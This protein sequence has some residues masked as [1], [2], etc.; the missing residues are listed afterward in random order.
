[1]AEYKELYVREARQRKA[2]HNELVELKYV[3]VGCQRAVLCGVVLR[4]VA[5]RCVVLCCVVLC[6]VVLCCVVLCCCAVLR[7]AALCLAGS[8]IVKRS[9]VLRPVVVVVGGGV[10]VCGRGVVVVVVGVG[11]FTRVFL[12]CCV[13]SI[14][15]RG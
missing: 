10:C 8:G 6:C 1:V 7:C 4:C 3:R 5:L 13:A 15:R 14:L 9:E 2:L 11:V 12:C